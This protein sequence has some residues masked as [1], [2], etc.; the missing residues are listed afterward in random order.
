MTTFASRRT[1][2]SVYRPILCAAA[3]CLS[4]ELGMAQESLEESK[5]EH[6]Q[7]A[8][9]VRANDRH[10]FNEGKRILLD[11]WLRHRTYDVA[12][13]LGRAEAIVGDPAAAARHTA[14]A[15]VNA[16]PREG[17]KYKAIHQTRMAKLLPRLY[18]ARLDVSPKDAAVLV[19]GVE[20]D[21]PQGI[22][23]YSTPGL[24]RIEFRRSG[25]VS[26]VRS[27]DAEANAK[28]EFVIQLRK[29][30]PP[31][32]P[33]VPEVV[34]PK[35]TPSPVLA[36][37][38]TPITGPGAESDPTLARAI[39]GIGGGLTVVL[40]GGGVYFQ[41]KGANAQDRAAKHAR[42]LGTAACSIKPMPADCRSL[43]NALKDRS[44]YNSRAV[45]A[46]G[47]GLGL[48]AVT[49]SAVWYFWPTKSDEGTAWASAWA[50]PGEAGIVAVGS[51]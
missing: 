1:F 9:G 24:H 2:R 37:S 32:P 29:E 39:L 7:F 47:L 22:G 17:S 36:K 28:D 23:L 43:D 40:L 49:A 51:F 30:E 5:L 19:D 44:F 35:R 41:L 26:Q 20:L 27:I 8:K 16:P 38:P 12:S 6:E 13:E 21:V 46:Y 45:V 25:Y 11:I 33:P 10:D 34:A 4:P 3:I 48:A 18:F 15:M 50:A 14:F 42:L 31:E